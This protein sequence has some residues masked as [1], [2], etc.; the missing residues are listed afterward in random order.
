MHIPYLRCMEMQLGDLIFHMSGDEDAYI[1]S[2][3]CL[4]MQLGTSFTSHVLGMSM[5]TYIPSLR[6]LQ[7]QLR[8]LIFHM[9][10]DKDEEIPSS[11]CLEMQLG[12]SDP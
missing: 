6:C 9:S 10:G 2:L 8:D 11:R 7:M 5:H 12:T 1:P 3:R 4:D